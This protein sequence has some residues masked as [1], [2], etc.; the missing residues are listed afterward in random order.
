MF[1]TGKAARVCLACVA[2]VLWGLVH[3][4]DE[5]PLW[6]RGP[7]MGAAPEQHQPDMHSEFQAPYLPRALTAVSGVAL[8]YYF[9]IYQPDG[10][11]A[12]DYRQVS[13]FDEGFSW[14]EQRLREDPRRLGRLFTHQTIT[15]EQAAL[16]AKYNLQRA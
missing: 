3:T 7:V 5:I 4:R 6:L 1:S 10:I 14:L 11:A 13:S 15:P 16:L 8:R 12:E 9:E 2:S